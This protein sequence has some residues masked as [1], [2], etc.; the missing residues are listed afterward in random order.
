MLGVAACALAGCADLD[1]PDPVHDI[2]LREGGGVLG[3]ITVTDAAGV[4]HSLATRLC[5]PDSDAPAPVAIIAHGLPEPG[6]SR[7]DMVPA[8][9]SSPAAAWFLERGYVVFL[10]LRRGY[11]DSPGA[12]AEN[13]GSCASPDYIRAGREGARDL[14][15]A[16]DY[17]L[18]QPFVRPDGAVL[19]GEDSG[20]WA[21]LGYASLPHPAA[22]AL[23]DVAG[24]LGGRA[25]GQLGHTCRPDLLIDAAASFGATA[26]T[27]MLWIFAA[28]DQVFPPD[29]AR[30][31][32]EA[33]L[34]AGGRAEL[35]QPTAPG[36]DGHALLFEDDGPQVWGTLVEA[37]LRG[38]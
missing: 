19:I 5:R 30:A 24:A 38:T 21:V 37:F 18:K 12:W 3:V 4:D 25:A 11:G 34:R 14:A 15:A 26:R 2:A 6:E 16:L 35:V 33:F 28:N 22:A 1:L 8:A 17:A 29:L 31:L 20:G 10:P 32:H 9:C 23:I 7:A 27:R 13:P 36:P